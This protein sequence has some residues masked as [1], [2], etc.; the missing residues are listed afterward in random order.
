[1]GF[2]LLEIRQ[3]ELG[4]VEQHIDIVVGIDR[5]QL[6]GDLRVLSDDSGRDYGRGKLMEALHDGIGKDYISKEW[7][8]V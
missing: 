8:A 6:D 3:K 5:W 2:E 1:V 7:M 4:M